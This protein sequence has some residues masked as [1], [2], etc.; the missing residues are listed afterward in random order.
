M[1]KFTCVF[2]YLILIIYS[3]EYLEENIE[4][5]IDVP[6]SSEVVQALLSLQT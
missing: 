6:T 5:L 1:I 3:A 4:S 2:N